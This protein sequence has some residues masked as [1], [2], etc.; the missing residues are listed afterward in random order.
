MERLAPH[1]AFRNDK[2][3]E[4]L[5]GQT[6]SALPEHGKVQVFPARPPAQRKHQEHAAQL[7]RQREHQEHAAQLPGQREHL[8]HSAQLP[9]Q[10]ETQGR[11]ALASPQ[12]AMP[13]W[14]R[15]V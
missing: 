8:E 7:P 15:P 12:A 3:A 1:L 13:E 4:R 5:P 14:R 11:S 10:R 6:Q 9:G 2:A